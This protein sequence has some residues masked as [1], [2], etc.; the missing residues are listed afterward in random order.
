MSTET[1]LASVCSLIVDCEHKT[2]PA[3]APGTEYAYSIG[4]PNIRNGRMIFG[5]AKRVDQDTYQR[6]TARAVPVEGDIILTREAPV[7]EA[8]LVSGPERVC[9]G[10]RTVLLRP[11]PAI[12]NPRYLHYRLISSDVQER[13]HSKAEGSTVPHLNVGDI[14]RLDVGDIP[15]L[16]EQDA[17]ADI[18]GALDDKIVVNDRI[19][20]KS[21]NLAVARYLQ[22]ANSEGWGNRR[23]CDT[24]Q[25]LSGGTP[26]TSEPTYWGGDIPWIS[27]LSLRSP[28]IFESTRNVTSL[29]VKSG[30]RL[31]PKGTILFVVRGSS[32]DSE[33][34]VGIT[35][36]EV[37]F[38]QDC[39]ALRVLDGIDATTLFVAL[40]ANSEEILKL[41]DHAGH[42]AGRLSTDLIRS[43]EVQLPIGQRVASVAD[44]LRPLVDLGAAK[45][46]E[47]RVL[48]S[49]RDALLPKLMSREIRIRDA[50]KVVEG[51][52]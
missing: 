2:A 49:L 9:L 20:A 26:R 23:L 32:L 24:S 19:A 30:T 13:M 47:S 50:E 4:T 39:K 51:A 28:W 48:A 3:A 35:Q 21:L 15:S 27:A 37:A 42:G 43:F 16:R 5:S 52:I 12:A 11:N 6:W 22:L 36:R 41:V 7:G 46:A 44:Q 18:L 10:Q 17:I 40:K 31:V 45:Q 29:G 25:W 1:T 38:G 8:A 33:F 14:R 34:R